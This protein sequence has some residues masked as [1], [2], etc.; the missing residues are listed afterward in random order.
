MNKTLFKAMALVALVAAPA[1][2]DAATR[3]FATAN[4]NMRSGPSTAYPAVVVIP[5]GA[6]VTVHGCLQDRNWC[7]VSFN[8][9]RGWVSGTYVQ[10][11]FRSSRVAVE[12]RRYR[13]LG[14]PVITFEV[15]RYW[16]QHYR[17]RDFYGQRERWRRPSSG[18]YWDAP[19][20][21]SRREAAPPPGGRGEPG[22][23]RQR[24]DMR[25]D[26][27]SDRRRMEQQRND[28]PQA[29]RRD[30]PP[31]RDA[32]RGPQGEQRM[33]PRDGFPCPPGRDCRMP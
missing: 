14:V 25:G 21:P 1:A 32:D 24:S 13:E 29:D 33:P 27:P 10:T 18:G 4:V 15:G 11:D 20:P 7:D 31:R 26:A 28:N 22:W 3:G 5:N 16:D 23:D 8:R 19:P 17:S 12:P 9:G 2:A 30:G 6:P